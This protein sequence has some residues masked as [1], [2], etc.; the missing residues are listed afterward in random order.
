[1]WMWIFVVLVFVVFLVV[2]LMVEASQAEAR[3]WT[4]AWKVFKRSEL[5]PHLADAIERS[6]MDPKHNHLNKLL[7]E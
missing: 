2:G 4:P 1:M 7:D 3:G 6:E 5:P